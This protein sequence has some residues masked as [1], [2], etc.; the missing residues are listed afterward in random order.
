MFIVSLSNEYRLKHHRGGT[1][2]Y[3]AGY[4]APTELKRTFGIAVTIDMSLLRSWPV[5]FQ[6]VAGTAR[7]IGPANVGRAPPVQSSTISPAWLS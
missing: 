4:A 7:E 6:P 3:G 2:G 1:V 5:M